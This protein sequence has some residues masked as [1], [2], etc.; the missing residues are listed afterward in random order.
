ML[1][2]PINKNSNLLF[3]KEGLGEISKA[4]LYLSLLKGEFI[5]PFLAPFSKEK[6]RGGTFQS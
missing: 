5:N 4:L 6:I 3:N 1:T 2:A